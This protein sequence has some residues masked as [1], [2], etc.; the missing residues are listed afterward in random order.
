MATQ[1]MTFTKGALD[2]TADGA[3]TRYRDVLCPNL[4]LEVV[5][6]PKT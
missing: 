5:A 3:V 1:E 6:R 2:K 4:Y